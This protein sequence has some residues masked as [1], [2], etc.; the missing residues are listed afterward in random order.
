LP[1]ARPDLQPEVLRAGKSIARELRQFSANRR[2]LAEEPVTRSLLP[3]TLDRGEV[4]VVTEPDLVLATS[5]AD[6]IIVLDWKTGYKYRT[7]QEAQDDFQTCVISWV[8]FGTYAEIDTI[9]FWYI[10]TRLS[11]RNYAK[12]TR[13]DEDNL[14]ARIGETVRLILDGVDDAWPEPAKCAHCDVAKW[15]KLCDGE[16]LDF[17]KNPKKY[18]DCFVALQARCN[19]IEDTLKAA[20]KAGRTIYGS[21][22]RYDGESKKARGLLPSLKSMKTDVYEERCPYQGRKT[23]Q[24]APQRGH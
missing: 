6:T 2:L 20:V 13:A 17:A 8:L 7:S 21:E 1:K 16:A 9:H 3:A 14:Q 22:C 23:G 15:C 5:K 11:N 4:L 10:N 19:Q 12:I 18:L 24:S